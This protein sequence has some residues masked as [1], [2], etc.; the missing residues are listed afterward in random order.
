MLEV[1]VL[2]LVH[3][4]NKKMTTEETINYASENIYR[5]KSECFVIHERPLYVKQVEM[6]LENGMY[7]RDHHGK[8]ASVPV[9]CASTD[10]GAVSVSDGS[11]IKMVRC[12]VGDPE[13]SRI[14]VLDAGYL[15]GWKHL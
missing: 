11:G 2:V 6:K 13:S 12:Q 5:T 9:Q 1:L 15:L 3:Q 14:P 8:K 10:E 4:K 7:A